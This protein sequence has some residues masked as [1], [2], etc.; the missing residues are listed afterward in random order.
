MFDKSEQLVYRA[1]T[2]VSNS[3]IPDNQYRTDFLEKGKDEVATPVTR[4]PQ[5]GHK[6]WPH[7]LC[8]MHQ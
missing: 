7:Q 1:L 8:Q 2:F 3:N 6:T 5:A 4:V